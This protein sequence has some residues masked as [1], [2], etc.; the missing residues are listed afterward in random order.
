MAGRY[1]RSEVIALYASATRNDS[2]DRRDLASE[3]PVGVTVA[4]NALVVMTND[5]RNVGVCINLGQ[6]PLPNLGVALH[7]AAFIKREAALLVEHRGRQPDLPDVM[8]ETGYE[9]ALLLFGRQPQRGGD[10]A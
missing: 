7:L 3:D 8:D 1:G 9:G 4:V 6:D 10:V 5:Q 2:R